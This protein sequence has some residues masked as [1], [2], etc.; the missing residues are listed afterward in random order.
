MKPRMQKNVKIKYPRENTWGRD[1]PYGLGGYITDPEQHVGGRVL[2]YN[3]RFVIVKDKYPKADIHLLVMPRDPKKTR[4]VPQ[5][6]FEDADFLEDCRR[7]VA[8]ARHMVAEELRRRY[9]RL[10]KT[11]QP[12]LAAMESE[13]LPDELPSGRDWEAHIISGIHSRPSM[14]HIHIHV[15]SP[16][17][18]NDRMQTD[19]HYQSFNSKFLVPLDQ[20]PMARDDIRTP[21][22]QECRHTDYDVVSFLYRILHWRENHHYGRSS[23][24]CF[25]RA[26][27][28]FCS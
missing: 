14:Q 24:S 27:S 16:D 15:L 23:G 12:R 19:H 5:D 17:M 2:S 6:A 13:D 22:G 21:Q 8:K 3:E 7:E 11:E 25:P 26:A 28:A 9:G 1:G 4:L 10:S 20:F 18:V